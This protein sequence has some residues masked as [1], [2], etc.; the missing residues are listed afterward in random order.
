MEYVC[1]V[2]GNLS[3]KDINLELSHM[4]IIDLTSDDFKSSPRL[5][6]S[7][8]NKEIVPYDSSKYQNAR[9]LKVR[10]NPPATKNEIVYAKNSTEI[11]NIKDSLEK[12]SSRMSQV[13]EKLDNLINK[14][15]EDQEK[16]LN[17]FDNF[18]DKNKVVFSEILKLLKK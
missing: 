8:R 2:I 1:N 9:R 4:E 14:I 3:I 12:I 5:R 6:E 15:A 18:L 16:F 17:S 10:N 7:I 13:G 11:Y